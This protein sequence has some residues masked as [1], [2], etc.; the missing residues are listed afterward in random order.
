[1][2]KNPNDIGIYDMFGNVSEW[3]WDLYQKNIPTQIPDN[4]RGPRYGKYR[5]VRGGS[6]CRDGY[7]INA[8]KRNKNVW[9]KDGKSLT[10]ASFIGFRIVRKANE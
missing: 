6:W 8:K 9:G 3:C 4:Y 2:M 5:C 7:I 10:S 1:M